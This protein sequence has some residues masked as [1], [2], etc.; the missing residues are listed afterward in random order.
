[1]ADETYDVVIIGAGP[2]GYVCA[3]RAG[4]LGLKVACVDAR[5]E[6]GGTCLN[7]GCIPSKALLE[8]TE[9]LWDARH[10]L[11]KH[12]ISVDASIDM[13]TMMKRKEK[14][15]RALTRGV[16]G[17]FKKNGVDRVIGRA[18]FR[19]KEEIE[20]TTPEGGEPRILR[21]KNFVVATGSEAATLPGV[22]LDGERIFTSTEALSLPEAPSHLVVIGAGVIGLEMGSVWLRL[23]A[24]VSVLEYMDR[25]LPGSDLEVSTTA[26]KSFKKQGFNFHLGV[27][28][29]R[30]ERTA[31]GIAVLYEKDGSEA[32]VEGDALL[33]AV[34]RRPNTRG[35]GAEEIGLKLDPKGRV[36]VDEH[37][38]TNVEGV[39]AIGD[40]IR[41]PML[42]HKA[43][44]EGI[45]VAE[46]IAGMPGHVN[47]DAIPYVVYTE[48]EIAWVGRTEEELKEAGIEYVAGRFPFMANGRAKALEAT[49]GFVKILAAKDTDRVLGVHIVGH[50]AGELI[51]EGTLAIELG[52][53]AEDIARTSHAHPTL[54]EVFREAALDA[55]GRVIHI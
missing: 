48:P 49:E 14:I 27:R 30:A 1:M 8:S 31:D 3:I 42:A 25:V 29:T 16:A 38:R 50:R 33:V 26:Q 53:S 35:L 23:G 5:S 17:L 7:I 37:F 28:V 52:A 45:A 51:M 34:G 47:Y 19:S 41:G 39:W 2:G 10:K 36:E 12:G 32:R 54:T 9:A 21:S 24:K 13:P 40:V 4:Q 22:E 44:D 6:L 43:E 55:N 46:R 20:V 18:R 11:S 15:V